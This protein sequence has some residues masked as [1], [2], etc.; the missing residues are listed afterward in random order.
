[1]LR[2]SQLRL[3]V[4][5]NREELTERVKKLLRCKETPEI[6]I[7]RRSIDARKKPELYFN[8]ILDVRVKNQDRIYSR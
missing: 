7:V 2:I 1:M 3:P 8:Y 6:F 4:E 5:H